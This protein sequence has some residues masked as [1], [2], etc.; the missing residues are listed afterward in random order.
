MK[1][2]E[3][4]LK[5]QE[6]KIKYSNKD[7]DFMLNWVMGIGQ[8]MGMSAAEVLLIA[9]Q[10]R[11]GK[12]KDWR[13]SFRRHALYLSKQAQEM[14]KKAYYRTA[15]QQYFA[16]CYSLRASLQFADPNQSAYQTNY[17]LME[18]YFFKAAQLINLPLQEIALPYENQTLPGYELKSKKENQPTVMVVGGGDTGRV[19]LFYFL[20]Y[21]A[22]Q[23]DYNVLMVDLPGQGN[24]PAHGQTFTV[25]AGQ[26]ISAVLDWYEAPS[27]QIAIM[28]LS[29]GGYFTAQAVEKDPRIK[30]WIASTPIYDIKAVFQSSFKAALRVPGPLLQFIGEMAGN[31]NEVAEMNLKKYAWQF[32]TENFRQAI[33]QVM[34][35]AQTVDKE[36]IAVPS[37]FLVG[38][39]E[40]PELLRQARELEKSL[41]E[42]GI[43]VTVWEFDRES[44]ADA[45]CQVNHLRLMNQVVLDWLNQ[46]FEKGI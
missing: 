42:R 21:A 20:G 40:S 31:F 11:N 27:D 12:P 9:D 36:K 34:A 35:K 16:A 26:A 44:A 22:W 24:N 39:G 8:Q 30:A 29:G 18:D 25:E 46:I 41:S 6:Q 3:E 23:A 45:H 38:S 4:I 19:D 1:K 28:G 15:A 10:I 33:D 17:Q 14:Q 37:L 13:G 32:G 7:M 43:P 5:R 2:S